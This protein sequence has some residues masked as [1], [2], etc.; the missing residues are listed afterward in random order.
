MYHRVADV[1]DDPH[2]LAMAPQL[3]Q[4]QLAAFVREF[5]V[6]PLQELV[7]RLQRRDVLPRYGLC[8]TF[9]DGY[10]DNFTTAL[11]ILRACGVPGTFFVAGA[12]L[13]AAYR[14]GWEHHA[15]DLY[16]HVD[17]ET[18]AAAA[19][20]PLVTIGGHTMTHPHLAQLNYRQQ[21]GEI[22]DNRRMLADITGQAVTLFA[23]PFGWVEDYRASRQAV[24]DA[25]YAAAVT[26][27]AGLVTRRSADLLELPREDVHA[28]PADAA[29]AFLRHAFGG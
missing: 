2:A 25:G 21:L 23:Y 18:L 19:A 27:T 12:G 5:T 28:M 3:F 24:A 11:P 13:D 4:E 16:E 26:T 6:L 7:G 8:V 29:V 15:P 17:A 20:D 10:A 14:Y 22:A 9:D 1:S